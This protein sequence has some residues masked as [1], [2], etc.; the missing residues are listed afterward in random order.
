MTLGFVSSCGYSL[1]KATANAKILNFTSSISALAF[2]MI[3]GEIY[4][5]AGFAM[6]G[7]Q[8]LGSYIGARMV[9]KKGAV[10]IRPVVVLA[11]FL[12]SIKL[13]YDQL[14]HV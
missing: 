7:G 1:A 8:V 10:L 9:L 12:T 14:T 13:L 4:W 6:M 5:S 11:C 3:F 2:F